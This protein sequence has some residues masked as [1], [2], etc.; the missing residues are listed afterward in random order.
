MTATTDRPMRNRGVFRIGED[1]LERLIDLPKG[2]RIIGFRTD[3]MRLCID[4]HLEGDGLPETHPLAEPPIVNTEDYVTVEGARWAARG[5][6]L[7]EM[8][9]AIVDRCDTLSDSTPSMVVEA[10][11][12]T[13]AGTYDPR[14]RYSTVEVQVEP[15]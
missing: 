5:G 7:A 9:Q 15:S 4:F 13:L 1:I 10:L 3:P 2:Q 6:E 12:A 14:V 8:V 11:R